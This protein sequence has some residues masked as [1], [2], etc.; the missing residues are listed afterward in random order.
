MVNGISKRVGLVPV[1]KELRQASGVRLPDSNGQKPLSA[2][3]QPGLILMN[4]GV[5][6]SSL[7]FGHGPS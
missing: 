3:A 7:L 1:V 6:F 2:Q 4:D 5:I